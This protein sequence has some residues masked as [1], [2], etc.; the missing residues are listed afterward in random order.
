MKKQIALNNIQLEL[1]KVSAELLVIIT[2]YNLNATFAL[3]V[4]SKAKKTI[5]SNDDY[6]RFLELSLQGRLLGEAAEHLRAQEKILKKHK[7]IKKT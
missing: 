2:K 7:N 3:E 5:T 4:I 1:D 6:V